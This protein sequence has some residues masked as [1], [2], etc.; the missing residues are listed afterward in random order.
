MGKKQDR[1]PPSFQDRRGWM[2][3]IMDG[4]VIFFSSY[5]FS[6]LHWRCYFLAIAPRKPCTSHP[7]KDFLVS[8]TPSFTVGYRMKWTQKLNPNSTFHS[9][10]LKCFAITRLVFINFKGNFVVVT[11]CDQILS[12]SSCKVIETVPY[13]ARLIFVIAM[14]G[15]VI[16]DASAWVR[17]FFFFR[18]ISL[19]KENRLKSSRK[20]CYIKLWILFS[21]G[22][23]DLENPTHFILNVTVD[24]RSWWWHHHHF[25]PTEITPLSPGRVRESQILF[26]LVF[27]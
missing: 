25:Q 19:K 2:D 21:S 23:L 6:T 13:M 16:L 3:G 12:T 24:T 22:C 1:S 27:F 4:W 10:Q 17:V 5:T 15:S 8:S 7:K 20:E 18:G 14:G 26:L 9:I 11:E